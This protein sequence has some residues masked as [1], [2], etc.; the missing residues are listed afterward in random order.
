MKPIPTAAVEYRDSWLISASAEA[1]FPL[2]CPVREYEWIET[3][4]CE[5]VRTLS[6]VAEEDCIFRT[7]FPGQGLMTWVVNRYEPPTAIEFTCLVPDSHAMRLKIRLTPEGSGTRLDWTRKLISIS[8][9]GDTR[10]AAFDAQVN[11]DLMSRLH[12]EITHFLTTG[13]CLH[14]AAAR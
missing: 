1:I 11:A 5:V 7:D 6:G 13:T 14:A 4:K 12:R 10:V 9:L 8:A 2:L 3:W